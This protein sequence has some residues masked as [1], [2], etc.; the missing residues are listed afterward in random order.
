MEFPGVVERRLIA[1]AF[2][3]DD[4]EDDRLVQRLEMLES[5][6]E[7]RQVVTVDRPVVTKAEFFEQDVRKKQILRAFLDLVGERAGRLARDFFDELGSLG[8][9]GG[10]GV[11]SLERVEIAGDGTDV[12]IDRPFVIIEDDDEFFG[13]LRDV[14]ERFERGSAGERGIAGDGDDMV[15]PAR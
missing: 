4:V 13:R 2:L 6:D 11:V 3:G 9:D 8:A 15:I 1:A 12:F 7:Q 5:A 10:V 14:V